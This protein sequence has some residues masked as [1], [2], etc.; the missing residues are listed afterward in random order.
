MNQLQIKNTI[1]SREVAEMIGKD[2][3][4]LMRDIRGYV[5]I[6]ENSNLNSQ[7]FF[8]PSSYK[9]DGNNKTYDCFELTRKGCD[10]VANKMTGEKGVL[11]TA[12]YVTKFEEMEKR[13][14]QTPVLTERQALLQSLKLTVELAE[15]MDEV[16]T[17]TQS[18]G[19]K[20]VEIEKKVDE[21]ITLHSGEQ[22][23]LQKAI[24]TKVY[25]IEP[26]EA[27]RPELFRQ[28]HR[29]IKDRWG[30][31]SYKDVKHHEF[32]GVLQYVEA[33]RPKKAN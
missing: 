22:R 18:H 28:L 9:V 33:W 20:L 3:S 23:R 8:L 19:L 6:L 25:N 16:K 12:M 15:D 21:Q 24:A 5:Q 1:N 11:F 10:M 14:N 4:N 26:D 13:T 30:V 27:A 7:D 29:E 2:H 31:G 17:I 32:R